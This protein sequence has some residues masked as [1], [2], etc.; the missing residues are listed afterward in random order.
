MPV[1]LPQFSFANF[2]K[3]QTIVC[4]TTFSTQWPTFAQCK[5]FLV[6]SIFTTTVFSGTAAVSSYGDILA[7]C[8]RDPSVL[9]RRHAVFLVTTLIRDEYLKWKGQVMYFFMGALL[10]PDEGVR[11]QVHASL[12][13]VL[14]PKFPKMLSN[15]FL[16]TMFQLNNVVHP[17]NAVLA[18]RK[19]VY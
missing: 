11:G 17:S 8:M 3:I 14:L 5:V 13:N 4:A 12:I 10:D 6:H 15:N 1:E 16:E 2:D 7:S 9:I 18:K 19:L